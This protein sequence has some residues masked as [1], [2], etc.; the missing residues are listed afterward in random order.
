MSSWVVRDACLVLYFE[1]LG[2]GI[3]VSLDF[4][5]YLSFV[6]WVLVFTLASLA[7]SR[8]LGAGGGGF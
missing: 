4:G 6:L 5:L 3:S 8:E 7:G 2:S 1:K